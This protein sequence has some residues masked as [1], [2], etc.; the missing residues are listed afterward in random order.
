MPARTAASDGDGSSTVARLWSQDSFALVAAALAGLCLLTPLLEVESA[1]RIGVLLVM[2]AFLEAVHGFRRATAGGQQEAWSGA[3]ITLC[4]GALLVSSPFLAASGLM[5]FLSG[6]FAL[7]AV[8]AIAGCWRAAKEQRSVWGSLLIAVLNLVAAAALLSLRGAF[9][10]WLL[11][12]TA[13][14][15]ILQTAWEIRRAAVVTSL[16]SGGVV[17]ESLG[18][19]GSPELV[20]A[21]DAMAEEEL[22][23]TSIDRGWII[24]F[25][26]TLFAI[27]VGRMGFDRSFLG[28]VSPV[29]AAAGDVAVAL[30]LAFAIVIPV[31]MTWRRLTRPIERRAWAWYFAEA[32]RRDNWMGKTVRAGLS[33]RLRRSIRLHHAQTSV[34]L[35]LSRGLQIGLPLS[36]IIAATT[37]V[38]GMSWYFD[39][40]NWAAGV[41]NSW[42]AERTDTW[43]E[44]MVRPL[45]PAEE[46]KAADQRFAVDPGTFDRG[47]DFSF[48][49]IGDPGEGDA[50]QHA[51]RA[52]VLEL[53]RREDVKFV[54]I[55]SD[56][57]YPTGA[58][59]NYEA[60]FWLPLMGTTKPVFAIPGNH[61]W[62]DALDAFAATFLEPDA[63]RLAIHGRVEA[64]AGVS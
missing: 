11:A 39:T 3:A 15:Q 7:G 52:Q 45:W 31:T 41:W 43:R 33:Y 23:R 24:G 42:A 60:N 30:L 6:W 29:V 5:L 64:D 55:S 14:Y 38:W 26:A 17:L 1:G 51:L 61:D 54:V 59:R 57:V 27:H 44:A 9:V 25:I 46:L 62:Y 20:K 35:A 2:A 22:S 19:A 34:L 63:A 12:L 4:M 10:E 58:M 40:E 48:L 56:V 16:D 13:A 37:P 8:R 21:A 18:L 50:S 32:S 36:A 49:V 28:I 53:A 47:G